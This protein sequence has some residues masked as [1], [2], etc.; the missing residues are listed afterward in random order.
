MSD[1]QTRMPCARS[2]WHSGLD[3]GHL[4]LDK[5]TGSDLYLYF[6]TRDATSQEYIGVA[7]SDVSTFS[8]S[9]NF[10]S[11]Y[12]ITDYSHPMVRNIEGVYFFVGYHTA[13]QRWEYTLG[14]SPVDFDWN[15]T[16]HIQLPNLM[17]KPGK[18]FSNNYEIE[19]G[20][21]EPRIQGFEILKINNK[22][23]A[24]LFYR[25]GALNISA[26]TSVRGIG[27]IRIPLKS[28]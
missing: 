22:Y 4:W 24:F 2:T 14:T 26:D 1:V 23:H 8:T 13:R 17:N 3:I 28:P 7:Q 25:A 9:V 16:K 21:K 10:P 15:N 27:T 11:N 6:K 12:I 19:A 20:I 5:S 18:W